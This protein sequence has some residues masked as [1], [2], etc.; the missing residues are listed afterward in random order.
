MECHLLLQQISQRYQQIMGA[1][2]LGITVHGSLAFGCFHWQSS[3]VDFLAVTRQEPAQGQKEA[4][5]Q[6]LLDLLPLSPPKGLEMSVVLS[7]FCMPFR[8]P[9]PFSLHFS[10]TH[11]EECQADLTRY[12]HSMHGTDRDLAAHFTVARQVGF[13]IYGPPPAQLFGPVPRTCY[14][15]SILRDIAD[16]ETEAP[17]NP[18]YFVLNQCRVLAYLRDASVCSK[19]D[20]GL[21]ALNR[22]DLC[23]CWA[24]LIR[25]CLKAYQTGVSLC[26]KPSTLSAFCRM[27]QKEIQI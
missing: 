7:K 6:I 26:L 4:M 8:Y 17:A 5:I 21:W 18:V 3:D 10:P 12:C 27:V 16:A 25:T 2:L 13:S 1:N 22:L 9:T 19:E 14:L 23:W 11:L 24:P 15:D 20:G